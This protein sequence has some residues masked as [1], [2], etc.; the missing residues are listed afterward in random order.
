[1]GMVRRGCQC[2]RT[3]GFRGCKLECIVD[4]GV[5]LDHILYTMGT[6]VVAVSCEYG[7]IQYCST[8]LRSTSEL[9]Y[10]LS[11]S[12]RHGLPDLDIPAFCV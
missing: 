2:R 8:Q 12:E 3:L 5:D 1:M 6:L 10:F 11:G 7:I 4:L 9:M